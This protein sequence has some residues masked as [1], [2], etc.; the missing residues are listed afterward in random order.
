MMLERRHFSILGLWD[1]LPLHAR[2][3]QTKSLSS[4]CC[5]SFFLTIFKI[6]AR[7][8]IAVGTSILVLL[9]YI[10]CIL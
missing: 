1:A 5:V 10:I 3:A 9:L 4:A 7:N 6:R 2:E 8:N